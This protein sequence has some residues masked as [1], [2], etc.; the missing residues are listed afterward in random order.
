M[1]S[2]FNNSGRNHAAVAPRPRSVAL[3]LMKKI[4]LSAAQ[5]SGHNNNNNNKS[6]VAFLSARVLIN[7]SVRACELGKLLLLGVSGTMV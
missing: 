4:K 3:V 1:G 5:R 6:W 7:Q 2:A